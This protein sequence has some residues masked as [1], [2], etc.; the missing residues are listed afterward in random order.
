MGR[1]RISQSSNITVTPNLRLP[2]KFS[3]RVSPPSHQ[4]VG[5]KCERS[6]QEPKANPTYLVE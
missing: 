5:D 3:K 4:S 1:V 6:P 2:G